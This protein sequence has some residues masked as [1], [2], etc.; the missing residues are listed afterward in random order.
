MMRVHMYAAQYGDFDQA[1]QAR[2]GIERGRGVE[3][4][5]SC[6]TCRAVCPH[7]V[8]IARRIGDLKLI[9]A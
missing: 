7:A 9:Y 1:R 4:C 2:R 6:G 8:G 3:A 5:A